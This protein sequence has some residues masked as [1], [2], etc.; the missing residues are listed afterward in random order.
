VQINERAAWRVLRAVY[1]TLLFL[2]AGFGYWLI[3]WT[4][5]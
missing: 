4:L 1:W 3:A 5:F 2:A